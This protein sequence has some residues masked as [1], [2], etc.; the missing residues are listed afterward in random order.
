VY[1]L[2]KE[3]SK[4]N[5]LEKQA[6]R[7]KLK[8]N[9]ISFGLLVFVVFSALILWNYLQQRKKSKQ[10]EEQKLAIEKLNN[11]LELKVV[12]RT[13]ALSEANQELIHKNRE[14]TEALFKGQTIERKRVGS[15]LHDNLGSTL[16]ALKWR[17]EA[18]NQDNW[19]EKEQKVYAGILDTMHNAYSEVRLISHNMLPVALESDGLDGALNKLI[20]E[21]NQAQKI[22]FCFI[23]NLKHQIDKKLELEVY[24]ICL[25]LVNNILKHSKATEAIL[26]LKEKEGAL[27]IQAKDNGVGFVERLTSGM[28]MKNILNRL[29]PFNGNLIQTNINPGTSISIEIPFSDLGDKKTEPDSENPSVIAHIPNH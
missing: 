5:E 22:D 6:M 21:I 15:E 11:T 8:R 2:D 9:V 4:S 20:D 19:S 14:I 27:L 17:L 24:S 13:K 25:E 26:Y 3:K 18:I 28:G 12:E 1:E 29:E 7:E 10:I 16:S 23:F